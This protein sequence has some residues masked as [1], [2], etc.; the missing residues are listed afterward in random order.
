MAGL[1]GGVLAGA[2]LMLPGLEALS[3][4][5]SARAMRSDLAAQITAPPE[6]LRPIVAPGLA[7]RAQDRAAAGRAL[8][9]HVRGRAAS[10]GVLVETL[11]P[12]APQPGIV[13]L[14]IR[15]SGPEKAVIAM[16]DGVERGTP[17]IRLRWW[18][19]TA[20]ADGGVRVEGEMAAA[21]E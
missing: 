2:A 12:T 20:L 10:A 21:W 17:L 9:T 16:I 3:E 11:T 8:A 7:I 1:V 4:L 6:P 13:T 14:G 18:R 5:W 19:A 15:L